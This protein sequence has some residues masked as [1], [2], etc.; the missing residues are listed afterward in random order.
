MTWEEIK[1]RYPD[2]WVGLGGFGGMTAGTLYKIH[3]FRCGDLVY[4]ECPI[5]ASRIYLPCQ[6]IISAT[7]FSKL[8][9][10][11]D[12]HHHKLNITIPDTESYIRN[13]T[14][15]DK[16]GKLYVLCG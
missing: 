15:E 10:E 3:L 8:I 1:Q 2:K 11:I 5:I 16:N 13:I 6:M 14:V 9:Y 4:H 12:D 7:M